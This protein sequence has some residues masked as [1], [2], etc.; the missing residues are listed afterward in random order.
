MLGVSLVPATSC[1]SLGRLGGGAAGARS[2]RFPVCG[3]RITFRESVVRSG[4]LPSMTR[5]MGGRSSA[6]AF[7][8]FGLVSGCRVT[9]GRRSESVDAHTC[10]ARTPRRALKANL[11]PDDE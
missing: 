4:Y 10:L 1:V 9:E 2:T 5:L 11:P 7:A 3:V 8:L 6:L